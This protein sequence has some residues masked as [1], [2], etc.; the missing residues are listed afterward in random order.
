VD[1]EIKA[2][3]D[4]QHGLVALR[5]PTASLDCGGNWYCSDRLMDNI[6][7]NYAVVD[8][9]ENLSIGGG[10]RLNA[11]VEA[12]NGRPKSLI[13]NS[14]PMMARNGVPRWRR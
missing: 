11:L 10:A 3:L 2:T 9:W 8:S 13:D 4:R 1:W 6:R 12:A 5:L 14:R 7:S